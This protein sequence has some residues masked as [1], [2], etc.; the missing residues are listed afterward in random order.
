MTVLEYQ[1]QHPGAFPQGVE[2][3]ASDISQRVLNF[4]KD[5]IYDELAIARGL[6]RDM[7]V[8]YFSQ[9][10]P[11]KQQ[12]QSSIRSLVTFRQANLMDSFHSFGQFDVIFCRNVLI[13]FDSVNKAKILQ[14]LSALLPEHG[15]ILLGAAESISGAEDFLKMEKCPR[16]LYYSKRS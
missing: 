10:D 8:K 14:K 2:I 3:L 1:R 4:A 11:K 7:Q 5:G 12:V 9:I 6:P 16:G 15:A 13:Y